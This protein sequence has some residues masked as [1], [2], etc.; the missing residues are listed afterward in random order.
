MTR[1]SKSAKACGEQSE[2][3]SMDEVTIALSCGDEFG[4]CG[5]VARIV[6]TIRMIL[7]LP[8]EE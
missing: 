2:G 5:T 8:P 3:E 6:A 1:F 7:S 4:D